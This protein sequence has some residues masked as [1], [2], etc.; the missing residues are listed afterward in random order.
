MYSGHDVNVIFNL[1]KILSLTI[2]LKWWATSTVVREQGVDK[3]VWSAMANRWL[4]RSKKAVARCYGVYSV[5]QKTQIPS[6]RQEQS[7]S[8]CCSRME[9]TIAMKTDSY[10]VLLQ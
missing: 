4:G 5:D 8:A 10:I 1:I 2:D 9:A 7:E 3:Q 6:H